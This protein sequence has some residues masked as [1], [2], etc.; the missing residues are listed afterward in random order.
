MAV[1]ATPTM[2]AA[3]SDWYRS[4]PRMLAKS[5]SQVVRLAA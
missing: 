3:M 1:R 2:L 5:A 4:H